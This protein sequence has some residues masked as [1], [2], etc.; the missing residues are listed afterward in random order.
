MS[1]IA[2]LPRTRPSPIRRLLWGEALPRLGASLPVSHFGWDYKQ[3]GGKSGREV[4]MA[5]VDAVSKRAPFQ[6]EKV[7]MVMRQVFNHAIDK[8]WLERNQN[9]ALNPLAKR[10]KAPATPHATLLVRASADPF[11]GDVFPHRI[12]PL[13]T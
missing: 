12:L 1:P 9:P 4:V 11:V 13:M 2:P 10:R 3:Q 5:Y 8:G 6:G 7:L